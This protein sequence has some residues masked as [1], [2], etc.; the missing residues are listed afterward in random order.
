MQDVQQMSVSVPLLLMLLLFILPLALSRRRLPP[1]LP[2]L[3]RAQ[4]SDS[5]ASPSRSGVVTGCNIGSR[6]SML[7]RGLPTMTL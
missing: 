4:S 5:F 3:P 2:L 7:M 1:P 6:L